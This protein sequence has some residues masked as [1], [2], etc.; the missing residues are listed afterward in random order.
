MRWNHRNGR[1]TGLHGQREI[2]TGQFPTRLQRMQ[3]CCAHHLV[4]LLADLH[5]LLA[6]GVEGNNCIEHID[7]LIPK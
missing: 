1:V 4:L 3:N 6:G 2:H 7:L 5:G